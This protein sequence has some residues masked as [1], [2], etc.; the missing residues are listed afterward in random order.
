M[1]HQSNIYK[2]MTKVLDFFILLGLE[3]LE[4][5]VTIRAGESCNWKKLSG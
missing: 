4:E 2:H 5:G 3:A 1:F